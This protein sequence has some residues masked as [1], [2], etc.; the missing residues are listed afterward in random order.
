MADNEETVWPSGEQRAALARLRRGVG[1]EVGSIPEIWQYMYEA[2][3]DAL[4]KDDRAE[5]AIHTALTLFG[6]HAQGADNPKTV[7]DEAAGSLGKATNKLKAMK[8]NYESGIL[9][10]FSALVTA[11]TYAEISTHARG[12]IQLLRQGDIALDYTKFAKDLYI[13]QRGQNVADQI[14]QD[15]GKD[16]YHEDKKE[17]ETSDE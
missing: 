11:K 16:L 8:P 9:H 2:L 7:H 12:I 5:N 6:M 14:L 1:K 10:R 17:G 4:A 13:L 15:W 3:P